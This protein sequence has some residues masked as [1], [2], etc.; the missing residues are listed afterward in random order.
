MIKAT[1]VRAERIAI[2]ATVIGLVIGALFAFILS[3]S[4][5][6]PVA[7]LTAAM[8]RVSNGDLATEIPA[9]DRKDE[10]GAMAVALAV[11]R[12]ALQRNQEMEA[13]AEAREAAGRG[14]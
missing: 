2:F 9:R 12:D 8:R 1:L 7:G 14:G 11:F 6:N 5:V 13:E 10:V 4:I 3:R